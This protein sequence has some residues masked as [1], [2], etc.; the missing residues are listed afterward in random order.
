MQMTKPRAYVSA[1]LIRTFQTGIDADA[2]LSRARSCDVNARVLWQH[3]I[4]QTLMAWLRDPSQLD[5]DGIDPPNGTIIRLS[6]DL[7]ENFRDRGLPAPDSVV[8]DPNGGIVFQRREGNVS[9]EFHVWEDA[10][11][12]YLRF[13]GTQ[14]VERHPI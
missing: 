4:D 5:D 10:S 13:E 9:E 14:L 6:M 3:V 2:P 7:A 11:V 8:P 12:E 1:A